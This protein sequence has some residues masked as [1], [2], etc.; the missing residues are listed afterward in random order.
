MNFCLN[1]DKFLIFFTVKNDLEELAMTERIET[2]IPFIYIICML[3][4]WFGPNA[5]ALY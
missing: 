5:N 3:M 2:L 1:I 4:E